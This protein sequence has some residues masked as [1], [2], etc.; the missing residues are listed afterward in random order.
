[1]KSKWESSDEDEEDEPRKVINDPRPPEAKR[2]K[3]ESPPPPVKI[4]K[5]DIPNISSPARTSNYLHGPPIK[6][7]TN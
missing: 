1:M 5:P 3:V 2:L 7:K 4:S 6:G